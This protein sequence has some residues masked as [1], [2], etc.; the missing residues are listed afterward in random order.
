[1]IGQ[2]EGTGE[3]PVLTEAE[4]GDKFGE[5]GWVASADRQPAA[6]GCESVCEGTP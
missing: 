1:M 2:V 4:L 5:F 6:F 3:E